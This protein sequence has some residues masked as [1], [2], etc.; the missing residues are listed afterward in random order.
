LYIF[1][2]ALQWIARLEGSTWN[3]PVSI[4]ESCYITIPYFNWEM[5]YQN[6][7]NP[8]YFGP[9]TPTS[10]YTVKQGAFAY[11]TTPTNV[12]YLQREFDHTYSTQTGVS[13]IVYDIQSNPDFYG[14][15]NTMYSV[16][17]V[18]HIWISDQ[19]GTMKSPSDPIFWCHHSNVD[20]MFALWQD[21]YDYES[22]ANASLGELPSNLYSPF[23]G[24]CG[25]ITY[26]ITEQMP[27]YYN[28]E[29]YAKNW[30]CS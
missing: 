13:G 2:S 3:P 17:S 6:I 1:E 5:N 9:S 18:P 23:G 21:C 10:D 11:W 4:E 15:T 24:S 27:Y 16:H 28:K 14:Y 19:M 30:D 7:W 20:R 29:S 22:Y 26:D 25:D 8:S 12:K